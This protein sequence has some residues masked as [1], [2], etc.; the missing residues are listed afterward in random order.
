MRLPSFA[1][2]V[3][4][5]EIAQH[6]VSDL[7]R[8]SRELTDA[9]RG[10]RSSGAR[11]PSSDAH[12]AA[13]LAVRM[14]ATYAAAESAFQHLR[15]AVPDFSPVSV[16]DLAA[17][18]G[19][20]TLAAREHFRA[21]QSATLIE[22]DERMVRIAHKLHSSGSEFVSDD[23]MKANFPQADL[24]ICAY[25]LKELPISAVLGILE[26]A[27]AA[28][29]QALVV[30]E[31]GSRDGFGNI[32]KA[33]QMLL[34]SGDGAIAAPCPGHMPCPLAELGD[35]CHFAARVQRTAL[36][37][38]L[39]EAELPYEDEK[40]S[41][42]IGIKSVLQGHPASARIV[43]RPEK[44]KGH[45]KLQLCTLNGLTPMVVTKKHG[46]HY[47]QAREAEWGDAF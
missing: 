34:A 38:R 11:L 45:V 20:A 35:W 5:A 29:R 26:R 43:R 2:E 19:T 1:V 30:I 22:R 7:A 47:R 16:L 40:F 28:T 23:V 25:A 12:C 36:H 17:G 31:P 24:V 44:L 3:I 15:E 8:A 46:N 39:K 18:P 13:Y 33:R 9:Y 42:V 41:Y 21:I 27:W 14:P 6:S 37:R 4:D 10:S 32:L